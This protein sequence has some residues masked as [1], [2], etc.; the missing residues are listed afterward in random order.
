MRCERFSIKLRTTLTIFMLT[1]LAASASAATEKVLY[2]FN[3]KDGAEP[4]ATL[5]FDVS[6]NLYGTTFSGGLHD[7]GAVFELMPKAGG[8]WTEKVLHSFNINDGASPQVGLIFDTS[9]NLYGTTYEGGA[10][11]SGT[12]FELSPKAGGAWTEKVIHSFD[13]TDGYCPC[14][15]LIVDVSGN[16][17]GTTVLGGASGYGT[18][19]E[20]TP[21]TGGTW[22]EKVL[23]SFDNSTTEGHGPTSSLTLDA[24]GDLYGTTPDGGAHG[25]GTVF[26]LK[27]ANGTWSEKVLYSFNPHTQDGFGVSDLIFDA[28]GNLYGTTRY[29]GADDFGLVFELSPKAGGRW[30][31]KVL[32]NF[33][34]NGK[35]GIYP[36]AG[37]IFDKSGNLYGTTLYGGTD[38]G[39]TVF[40]LTPTGGGNWTETRLHNFNGTDGAAPWGAL[41]FDAAG[42]LY[43]TTISGGAQADG[44]VFEIAP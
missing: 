13:T 40:Q 34:K 12:V 41:I 9:G 39:G 30:T 36:A 24:S 22:T 2:S 31:E 15:A 26:E 19:F 21:T 25:F 44:T 35:D 20:L 38:S 8:G 43:G 6:G 42:N 7:H 23:H 28:S 37:L 32:H 3:G 18:V 16:L 14:A 1:L 17:Y 4:Y 27:P 5:I 11:D 10:H 29:G 33:S